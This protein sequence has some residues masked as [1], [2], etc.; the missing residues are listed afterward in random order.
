MLLTVR[1]I[2]QLLLAFPIVYELSLPPAAVNDQ[3]CFPV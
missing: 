1:L 3:H 2:S